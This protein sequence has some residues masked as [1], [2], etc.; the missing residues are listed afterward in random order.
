[1]ND[2]LAWASHA[3]ATQVD[4]EETNMRLTSSSITAGQRVPQ[5]YA[6]GKPDGTGKATLSDNVSPHLAW[7]DVPAGTKSFAV[8]MVDPTVPAVG[9]DMNQ[10]GKTLPANMPR[11]D[12][13]HWILID[14][15]ASVT[16][17]AEGLHS[18]GVV[19][20]GKSGPDA[21]GGTRHGVNNYSDFY[22]GDPDLGGD[23]FGYDGPFPPWNDE[24]VHTYNFTVYAVDTERL[25]VEGNFTGPDILDALE[26]HVLDSAIITAAY[27]VNQ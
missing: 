17:L 10:E 12:F 6:F 25:P 4:E 1:M 27:S 21:P 9:D 14:I 16:E 26:G 13:Y 2:L 5:R 11:T 15:P 24:L 22:Q 7:S 8:V 19:F 23:Y 18:D 3:D 20:G